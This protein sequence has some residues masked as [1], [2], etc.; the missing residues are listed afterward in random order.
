MEAS[1]VKALGWRQGSLLPRP[2]LGELLEKFG[3]GAIPAEEAVAVVISHDCDVTNESWDVEPTCE[4]LWGRIVARPD[5]SLW[6][7]KNPRRLQVPHETSTLEF[8]IHD[9]R[10]VERECLA[11]HEPAG[12]LEETQL[13]EVRSWITARYLRAAFP[14]E[15]NKRTKSAVAKL[16]EYFKKHDECA[17]LNAIYLYV[18]D[19]ELKDGVDYE[20]MVIGTMR[21]SAHQDRASREA[22]NGVLL[23]IGRELEGCDGIELLDVELRSEADFSVEDWRMAKRWDFDDLTIRVGDESPEPDR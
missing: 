6:W 1:R 8:L 22:A 15:L 16:R 21:E 4:V 20:I 19:D 9:R 10:I 2:L 11:S 3:P 5:K 13:R 18:S 12:C 23:R 7:R 17:L 14:D